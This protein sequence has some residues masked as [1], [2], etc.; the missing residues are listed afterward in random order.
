MTQFVEAADGAQAIAAVTRDRFDLIVTDYNMPLLDG[1]GFVSY[2]KQNP[3]TASVPIILVTTET[4]PSKL[5]AVRG[6]GVTAVCDKSFPPDVVRAVIERFVCP[7]LSPGE[8]SR[9]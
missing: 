7:P 3:D 8:R 6:L 1:H 2:L 4:D 9:G 5:A